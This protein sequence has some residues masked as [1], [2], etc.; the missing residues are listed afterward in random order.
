MGGKKPCNWLILE[1]GLKNLRDILASLMG[2]CTSLGK[3]GVSEITLLDS[4][5]HW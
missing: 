2:N 3:E 1:L 4:K 5:Q